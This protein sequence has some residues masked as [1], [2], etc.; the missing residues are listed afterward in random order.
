MIKLRGYKNNLERMARKEKLQPY[1]SDLYIFSLS[2]QC[3]YVPNAVLSDYMTS[4]RRGKWSNWSSERNP[5]AIGC[6]TVD[7][8]FREYNYEL[9]SLTNGI[10]MLKIV[11]VLL[12]CNICHFRKCSNVLFNPKLYQRNVSYSYVHRNWF[13]FAVKQLN[14]IHSR[15]H[16]NLGKKWGLCLRI[17]E[18]AG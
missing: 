15:F 11:L 3:K 18:L 5:V 9:R 12:E 4:C 14:G 7:R 6:N 1:W 16:W 17:C 2:Q 10:V 13:L 8:V